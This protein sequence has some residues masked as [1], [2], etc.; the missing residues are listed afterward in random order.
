MQI[1]KSLSPFAQS[2]NKTDQWMQEIQQELGTSDAKSA[3]RAARGALHALRDQLITTEAADLAAQLPMLLRGLYFEGYRPAATPDRVRSCEGFLCHVGCE[4]LPEADPDPEAA[5]KAVFSVIQNHVSA[6]EVS[7]VVH[8]LP[9]EIQ[10]L[11]PNGG[12]A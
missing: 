10:C 8:M 11:W 7:D 4:L 1:S 12:Q 5:A 3:Y 2:L 6:G 9:A